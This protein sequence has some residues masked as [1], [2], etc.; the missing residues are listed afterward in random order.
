[1]DMLEA[2]L[3]SEL[4]GMVGIA[5]R[6]PQPGD[7]FSGMAENVV[8]QAA[9]VKFGDCVKLPDGDFAIVSV[10]YGDD[11]IGVCRLKGLYGGRFFFGPKHGKPNPDKPELDC[12]S[13]SGGP[14][15]RVFLKDL[16]PTTMDREVN[17]WH[18]RTY[19]QADG[20][21]NYRRMVRLWFVEKVDE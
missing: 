12:A 4:L 18:W 20:G 6:Q 10:S 1:M 9:D 8:P 5:H 11:S 17:C 7:V 2:Q 3:K 16:V 13:V 14:F 19:P 21:V 15:P